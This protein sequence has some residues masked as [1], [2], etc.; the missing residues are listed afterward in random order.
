[1]GGGKSHDFDRWF[2][3][4][5]LATL[6]P[7]TRYTD[8]PAEVEPALAS[9][10]VLVLTNNQPLEDLSLRK[11]LFD[12]VAKGRGLVVVHPAAW[13]NWKDWPDYNRILVGGGARGHEKYSEFDVTVVDK[14]HAVTRG[15]PATFSLSDELY[16]FEKNGE[17]HTLAVGRSRGTGAEYP[18]AW[19]LAH[20]K[21]RIVGITLGHDGAAHQHAAYRALLKNAV[22][23]VKR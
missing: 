11:A 8:K 16:R 13:Y 22:S 17:I 2:R 12:F 20:G 10:D 4:A 21:G 14:A 18:V 3:D 5:D 6:G 23:W 1:V 15:V 9:T 7:G 19:T